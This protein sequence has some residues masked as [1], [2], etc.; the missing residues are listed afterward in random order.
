MLKKNPLTFQKA[1]PIFLLRK[2]KCQGPRML[3][4]KL[5]FLVFG[6]KQEAH[7]LI[8]QSRKSSFSTPHPLG[9][10]FALPKYACGARLCSNWI[11]YSSTA[12]SLRSHFLD[13]LQ[14][15]VHFCQAKKMTCRGKNNITTTKFK[16]VQNQSN[17][18]TFWY[19]NLII[20]S[21]LLIIISLDWK[22]NF[23]QDNL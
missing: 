9:M 10:N 11:V 2:C 23:F 1:S 5:G 22:F 4:E 7:F 21:V 8:S 18:L 14:S 16:K 13:V 15:A 12:G 3:A 17:Y 20:A 19:N 6:E